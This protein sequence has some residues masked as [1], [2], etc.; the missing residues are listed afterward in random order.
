LNTLEGKDLSLSPPYLSLF[1]L[2]SFRSFVFWVEWL[3]S[4]SCSSREICISWTILPVQDSWLFGTSSKT[5]EDFQI[6]RFESSFCLVSSL[7]F[8]RGL[9]V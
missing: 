3:L 4:I 7:T 1:P 5:K 8:L 9:F 2:V 6:Q